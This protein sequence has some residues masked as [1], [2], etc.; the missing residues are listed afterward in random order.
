LN[1][2]IYFI[3]IFHYNL[4]LYY[5]GINL[6]G[7]YLIVCA[8]LLCFINLFG[9]QCSIREAGTRTV[10]PF[11]KNMGQHCQTG[12]HVIIRAYLFNALYWCGNVLFNLFIT[13]L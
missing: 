7:I 6:Y 12:A 13:L 11:L 5:S 10:A 9:S 2:G 4:L 8:F 3:V 1:T